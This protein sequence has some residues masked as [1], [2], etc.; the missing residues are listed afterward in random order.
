MG[1]IGGNKRK[2]PITKV[3]STEIQETFI[4][5][6]ACSCGAIVALTKFIMHQGFGSRLIRL[7]NVR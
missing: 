1:K 7:G 3:C 5:G 2:Q 4:P 6:T